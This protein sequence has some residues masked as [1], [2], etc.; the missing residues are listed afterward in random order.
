MP[1]PAPTTLGQ[2]LR[3]AREAANMTQAD[4]AK[5]ANVPQPNL[6]H[7]ERDS[8]TPSVPVL[9]RLAAALGVTAGE[10]ID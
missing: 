9:Q 2:R 8:M 6:S 7:Y 4:L 10:L 3:I 5:A 1:H